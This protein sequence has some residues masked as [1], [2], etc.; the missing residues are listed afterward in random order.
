MY[1][2]KDSD[3][4]LALPAIGGAI[5]TISSIFGGSNPKDANR[6]A[7]NTRAYN[8]AVSGNDGVFYGD[9]GSVAAP[10]G[11]EFLR[12][13]SAMNDADGGW[14]T[15]VATDDAKAKYQRALSTINAQRG[16]PAGTP[17]Q[18]GGMT[19]SNVGGLSVPPLLLAGAAAVGIFL[20]TQN[21][22]R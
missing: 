19:L 6:I 1:D 15:Q 5:S 17:I 9:D 12:I 18:S 21:R 11:L 22:R 8:Q 14:A 7:T 16:V 3:L 20:L 10:S 4:G 2:N 13:H